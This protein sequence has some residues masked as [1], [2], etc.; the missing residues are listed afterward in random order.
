MASAPKGPV[1][2]CRVARLLHHEG[3]FV[4]R[5]VDLQMHFGEP[6]TVTDV[7]VLALTFSPS[8]QRQVTVGEC[9]TTEARSAPSSADRLLWGAG[10]RRLVP[11]ADRH[12][13]ATVKLASDRVRALARRLGAEVVDERD[14][15]RREK[16][17]GLDPDDL[18]GPHD[19][20]FIDAEKKVFG[21]V[22]RD[23]ELKRVWS[24]VRS[25]FWFLDEVYGL[26][27]ALG[28]L[29]LLARR[30]HADLPAAEADAVRWLVEEGL[31][32]VV[33]SMIG[34]AGDCYRQ[35]PDVFE[36]NLN[37]RLAE[38]MVPYGVMQQISKEVDKYLLAAL[39]EAGVDPAGKLD[40]LGALEPKPPL[41]AEPLMEVLERLASATRAT[42]EL[43]RLLDERIA[44]RRGSPV[45]ASAPA[46][47]Q[48][49]HGSLLL[50][51]IATFLRAQVKLS[52]DLLVPMLE[53]ANGT[54]EP[55]DRSANHIEPPSAVNAPD[56]RAE[57]GAP[58]ADGNPGVAESL[59]RDE[60]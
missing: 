22:K 60:T 12:M 54:P 19:P 53:R 10:V 35:P 6:F 8:L 20:A 17:L 55:A 29:Q 58:S 1:F 43:G 27:R 59:F 32:S 52:D 3:A 16:L 5:A 41:Y 4:R 42:A 2:E 7:D 25:D 21:F 31:A 37:H 36:R 14:L 26:K 57:A 56:G 38:G 48:A 11:G 33:V 28:A 39:R 15:A 30:W 13:L 9:K 24:F 34:V 18:S 40:L 50:E 47:P 44:V 23:D 51:T 46:V 49:T 45:P